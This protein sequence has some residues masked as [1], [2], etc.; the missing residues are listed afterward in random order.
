VDKDD[1]QRVEE[2]TYIDSVVIKEE[3]HKEGEYAAFVCS[4]P[5]CRAHST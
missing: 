3:L 2:F 1:I 4:Y 5:L